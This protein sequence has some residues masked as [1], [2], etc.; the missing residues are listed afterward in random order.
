MRPSLKL[1]RRKAL[2]LSLGG[3]GFAMAS[4][5]PQTPA[6]TSNAPANS[7]SATATSASPS[8]A[9]SAQLAG[10]KTVALSGAGATF[11]APLYQ[12]WFAALWCLQCLP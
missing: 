6:P 11:P 1:S 3:L 2:Y 7:P 10:G 9:A 4:C 12:R 5:A 8:A